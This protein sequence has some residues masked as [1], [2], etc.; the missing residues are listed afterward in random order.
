[1]FTKKIENKSVFIMICIIVFALINIV[2]YCF[3]EGISGNDFWWHIKVGEYVLENRTVPTTDIFSWFGTEKGIPWTAHEWLA[4]VIFY[5][6]F[7]ATGEFGIFSLSIIC[8][9]LIIYLLWQQNK[10]YIRDNLLIS[11]VFFSL[12]AVLS[13]MFFYGRPHVFSFFFLFFELKIL[14]RFWEDNN[15]KGIFFLP[16][17]SILWSNIHGGSSGLSYLLCIV[18]LIAGTLRF[19]LGRIVAAKLSR[20]GI[21]ILAVI[22]LGTVLG[23][24]VNPIGFKVWLYPYQ[25]FADTLSMTIISEWRAPDAKDL[26]NLILYFLPIIIMSIGL[27]SETKKI[28]FIDLAV[29]GVFLFL[30]FRSA[31][32]IV[33]W[34][35]SA[36]FYAFRYMPKCKIK[37][38]KKLSEVI[39]VIAV[40]ILLC[41][42]T[43]LSISNFTKTIKENSIISKAMSDEAIQVVKAENPKRILNDYNVGETLIYNNIPVFI[44][45]RADLY[46]AEHI[47]EDGVS[48]MFLEQANSDSETRYVDVEAI[49]SKYDFDGILILNDRPLYSY[50]I[51]NPSRYEIVFEDEFLGYFRIIHKEG[52]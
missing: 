44:D 1:M 40:F 33:M 28:R 17:I 9:S 42:P 25:S 12:F 21:L 24:L 34:Y 20:K 2:L 41:V 50:L 43:G 51:G 16:L 49:V 31:R 10:Q 37:E 38:I 6:I 5:L 14:Y 13:S 36:G 8:A 19:E 15:Y 22:T 35:I 23:I 47:L 30:F 45:A 32:F 18:F 39:A 48:L 3:S 27:I 11:G 26:G 7:N 4:D 46:A 29:M 52:E